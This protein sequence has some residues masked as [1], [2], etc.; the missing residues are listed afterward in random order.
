MKVSFLDLINR[1]RELISES[2]AHYDFWARKTSI[3]SL[4][5]GSNR[6]LTTA[7]LAPGNEVF[8]WQIGIIIIGWWLVDVIY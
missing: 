7:F 8:G 4:K 6:A 2:Q 5:N 1:S 3:F